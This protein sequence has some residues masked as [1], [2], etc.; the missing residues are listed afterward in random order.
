MP[1]YHYRQAR[2]LRN[3][4][5]NTPL[6]SVI[7]IAMA[8]KLNLREA[9]QTSPFLRR[10]AKMPS[11]RRI[12]VFGLLI[13][14]FVI[15][16]LFWTASLRQ[17][18][19]QDTRTVGDFYDKTV[20]ALNSQN[21]AAPGVTEDELIAKKM[22]ESLKEAAQVAKDNANAK[23]PKPDPPSQVV[24]VGS[25]AE[26]ARGDERSVAGRKKF[27][28]GEEQKPFKEEEKES[29]E[30]HEIEVELNSIL[31]KSPSKFLDVWGERMR[32][33]GLIMGGNSYHIFEIILSAFSTSKRNPTREIHHRSTTPR[34]GTRST[35]NR[36]RDTGSPCKAYG[37]ENGAQCADKWSQY[38][39]W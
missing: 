8:D 6:P 36:R 19:A 16:I 14:L 27:G 39:R 32:T 11:M 4:F 12:K 34:R 33:E 29:E 18:R 25:A 3:S 13:F 26:G 9:I 5:L 24:G 2:K 15:T 37:K 38:R 20:N 35:S 21:K 28:G 22:A 7:E 10:T 17:S 23:A 30:D 1:K 31:K